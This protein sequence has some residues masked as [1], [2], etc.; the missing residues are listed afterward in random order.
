MSDRATQSLIE[1]AT[2]PHRERDREGRIVPAPAWWDLSP[3]DLDELF[4]QQTFARE[5]ERAIDVEGL[6]S[7]ARAV[8]AW[9]E[10]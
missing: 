6:S 3:Q 10:R 4:V 2:T 9:I 8:L 1:A 7:T 5:I